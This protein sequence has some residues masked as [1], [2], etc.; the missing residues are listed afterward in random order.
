MNTIANSTWLWIGFAAFILAMLSL[1]L[2][3]FNRKAHT[4]RY[5]EATIWSI[6]WVTMAMIFAGIVFWNQGRDRGL[7]FVTGYL[8]ELS[9]SVDNLFVFLLIFSYF[10]VPS[11][12]Q[13]RVLFWGLL[14][15][16]VFRL[17]MI[18][19]GAA[20]IMRF[21]WIIYIFGAFLV[22]TGLKMFRQE[23]TS[24]QPEQNPIVRLVTRNIPITRHYEE[25][26]FFTRQAGRRVGTLLLLV[27]VIVEVSD[28]VFAVDSIP[29]IF[30]VT[31]NTFIVYTSNVFAI[32]GLRS[33]YFLLAGVVERF[34]HLKLGLAI[35]LTFIGLKMLIV[36]AG[37]EIPITISLAVVVTV[38]LV[39]ITASLLWPKPE[40]RA[41]TVRMEGNPPVFV[42]SGSG[43]MA[44]LLIC[45]SKRQLEGDDLDFNLWEIVPVGGY[46]RGRPVEDIGAIKYG[47]VP[48]GY[49]QSYPEDGTPPPPLSP[50]NKYEYWFDTT[51]APH[52]RS[53][54]VIRDIRA[55]AVED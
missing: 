7:E 10:K 54:F 48:Q 15:A 53:Y 47:V 43:T 5:R 40:Q 39:A 19:V 41:T 45:G 42:L 26:K 32:L 38:L 11:R 50:G 6:V 13:H 18:F 36:M 3:L 31:T 37:V 22:Y 23:E 12:Y 1:D 24:I 27:L 4:I 2:G 21:Q 9:L 17:T 49:Q 35:V 25:E 8:I 51:D 29:A 33:M 14:G 52:A 30:A 46:Q 20:L 55:V 34:H 44:H 28:L 16:L